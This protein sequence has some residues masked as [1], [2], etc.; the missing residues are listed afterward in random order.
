MKIEQ[1][2]L[3]DLRSNCYIIH[4]NKKAMIIDPGFESHDVVDFIKKEKLIPQIIYLTHGHFD[5]I[6]G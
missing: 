6:G 1:F 3:G 5:H 2:V 4:K